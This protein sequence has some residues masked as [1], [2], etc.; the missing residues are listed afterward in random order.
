MSCVKVSNRADRCWEVAAAIDLVLSRGVLRS[1]EVSSL[2]SR[3]QFMEGQILERLGRLSLAELRS[4]CSAAGELRIGE[5]ESSAFRNLRARLVH[6]IP[7][8]TPSSPPTGC[9]RV[10]TDGA[11]EP[12]TGLPRCTMGGVL[13]H[14]VGDDWCTRCFRLTSSR[15][16]REVGRIIAPVEFYAVVVARR[17]WKKFLDSSRSLIFVDHAGVHAACVSG[18][19]RDKVWRSLLLELELCD[20]VPMIG[21]YAGVPSPSTPAPCKGSRDF[22]VWALALGTLRPAALVGTS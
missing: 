17:L 4:L 12:T 13:C 7:R 11:C 8:Q 1:A 16:H 22:P 19:S 15:P 18:A 9:T 3:I 6:G 5:L 21:W 20:C 14:R 10:F 2:F